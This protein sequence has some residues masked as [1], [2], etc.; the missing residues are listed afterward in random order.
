MS[1][2]MPFV[3]SDH[4]RL[5][6]GLGLIGR[7]EAD[8]GGDAVR[9]HERHVHAK[10]RER[11]TCPGAH[12]G[13]GDV[14]NPPAEQQQLDARQ[15]REE[16][17]RLHGVRDDGQ[18][19][20]GGQRTDELHRRRPCVDEDRSPVG[21]EVAGGTA[22]AGLLRR[23]LLAPGRD[24]RF[25]PEPLDV[26][27]PAMDSAHQPAALEGREVATDGLRCDVQLVGQRRHLDP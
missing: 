13:A 5:D 10:V 8:V 17:G 26:D 4:R 9:T 7:R 24:R 18:R 3:P 16:R 23:T 20:V 1:G 21:K 12:R 22:D 6:L 19:E 14:T 27:R 11:A 15:L 25:V 2:V